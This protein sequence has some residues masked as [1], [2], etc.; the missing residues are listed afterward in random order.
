MSKLPLETRP[1]RLAPDIARVLEDRL[2]PL[3][4]KK[5]ELAQGA[6]LRVYRSGIQ[7]AHDQWVAAYLREIDVAVKEAKEPAP[8]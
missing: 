7:A 2:R 1:I 3:S 4:G 6:I 8:V 5:L